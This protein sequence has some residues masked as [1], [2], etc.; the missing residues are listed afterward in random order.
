M[1]PLILLLKWEQAAAVLSV[2]VSPPPHVKQTEQ[3]SNRCKNND[4]SFQS[5]ISTRFRAARVVALCNFG[6]QWEAGTAR[7]FGWIM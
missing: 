3:M 6:N 7:E 4:G 2:K 1:T 5:F